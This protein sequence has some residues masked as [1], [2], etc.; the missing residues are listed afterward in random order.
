MQQLRPGHRSF[1]TGAY[2]WYYRD[3]IDSCFSNF[4]YKRDRPGEI[5]WSTCS[6]KDAVGEV[7]VN[8]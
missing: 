4:I 8:G 3:S 1:Q 5:V 7:K 2:Y 6:L